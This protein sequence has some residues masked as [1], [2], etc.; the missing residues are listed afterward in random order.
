MYRFKIAS[1]KTPQFT[2]EFHR[3]QCWGHSYLSFTF[4]LLAVSFGIMASTLNVMLMTLSSMCPQSPLLLSPPVASLRVSMIFS[5][6]RQ[7]TT[8]NPPAVKLNYSSLTLKPH[9]QKL[10]F[11]QSPL[12]TPPYLSP[13]GSRAL[14]L[15]STVFSPSPVILTISPGLPF[16]HLQNVSRLCP[17]LTQHCTEDLVNALV[18][19]HINYCNIILAGIPNKLIN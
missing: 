12:L 18:T 13:H 10:I 9:S 14:V 11:L 19:S 4:Y 5:Y 15:F 17:T 2:T 6:G 7:T 1:Q 16:F 8:S 3:V